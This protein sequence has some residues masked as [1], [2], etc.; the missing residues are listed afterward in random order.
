MLSYGFA[1]D[2]VL[3]ISCCFGG[4]NFGHAQSVSSL[5]LLNAV[6]SYVFA[7]DCVFVPVFLASM[8]TFD[9]T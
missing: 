7:A 5:L 3:T 4:R 6:L 9:S 2:L 8:G 1:P